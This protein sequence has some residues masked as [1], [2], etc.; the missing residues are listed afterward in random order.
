MENSRFP[1]APAHLQQKPVQVLLRGGQTL[2]GEVHIPEGLPLLNFLGSKR[3]F[4]NLTSVRRPNRGEG[5]DVV[6]HL[7]LRMSNLVWVIPLDGTLHLS[8][9]SAP[10]HSERAVEL[11]LVDGLEL[12][13]KLNISK[14]QRMS[15]FLDANSGFVPL[16]SAQIESTSKVI[17]R[18]A[19]NHEAILA[20]RELSS[21][22]RV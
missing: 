13:V 8:A 15:D 12:T 20:I 17:D 18:L 19:V 22:Q 1:R 4:L 11:Q 9:A 5:S 6:E 16:F 2:E 10:V 3:F 7:S 14:E 21:E